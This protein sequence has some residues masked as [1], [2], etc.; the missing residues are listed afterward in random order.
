MSSNPFHQKGYIETSPGVL[1]RKP[2]TPVVSD[3]ELATLLDGAAKKFDPLCNSAYSI[4]K[5]T[6]EQKLNKTEAA[7]L[8][9]LRL[10]GHPYIGIQNITL[11]L[12]DDCRYTCDFNS[13]DEN[14][15]FVFHEVKGFMRD[16][17]LVKL[18]TA[19]RLFRM[20]KFVL[21]KKTKTGWDITPVNP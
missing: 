16:D 5:C 14:G 12:A 10:L 15:Q 7:Y 17:A 20:F 8:A 21:V 11:K 9:R 3:D 13:I 19:A 18:K 6:D 1:V 4:T 2:V